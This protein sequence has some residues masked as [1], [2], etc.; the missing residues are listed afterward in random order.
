M[1]NIRIRYHFIYNGFLLKL[2][3][4]MVDFKYHRINYWKIISKFTLKCLSYDFA[5]GKMS[6]RYRPISETNQ[7]DAISI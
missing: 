1:G 4:F 6:I 7:D 5:D 3:D 2:D